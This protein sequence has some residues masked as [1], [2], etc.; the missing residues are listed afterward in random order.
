[1][2]Q[3]KKDLMEKVANSMAEGAK[4]VDGLV[5]KRSA[6]GNLTAPVV[7][8]VV[9]VLPVALVQSPGLVVLLL[10]GMALGSAPMLLKN[11][12]AAKDKI[13]AKAKKAPAAEEAD[14]DK[15]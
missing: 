11:A 7:L 2:D 13:A 5:D 3:K 8:G 10:L 6:L 15:K 12:M 1:M 9:L 4:K 14:A